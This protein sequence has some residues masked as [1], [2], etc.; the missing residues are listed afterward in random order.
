MRIRLHSAQLRRRATAPA[1]RHRRGAIPDC[2]HHAVRLKFFTRDLAR[3]HRGGRPFFAR[4]PRRASGV[5]RTCGPG[6]PCQRDAGRHRRRIATG[7]ASSGET[8]S[9][10]SLPRSARAAGTNR[11][12]SKQE[13]RAEAK[14]RV[15][16]MEADGSRISRE[17]GGLHIKG[18]QRRAN[19]KATQATDP[20]LV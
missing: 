11:L 15:F 18:T 12:K 1:R 19:G 8:Q 13:D 2:R 20:A 14:D 6:P 17:S 16:P 7:A 10:P 3:R 9:R 4:R 5:D